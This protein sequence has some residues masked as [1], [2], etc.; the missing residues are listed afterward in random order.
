MT[1]RKLRAGRV[2]QAQAETWVG[3]VGMI[4]YNEQTGTLRIS[5]G[6]TPGGNPLTLVAEDF[7][8][9]FGDFVAFGN[10]Q[11]TIGVDQDFNIES[12]G[13]GTVNIVGKLDI[14]T[15]AQGVGG[16]AVFRINE[17]GFTRIN[18][19]PIG[20]GESGLL[21]TSAGGIPQPPQVGG[22]ILHLVG[23]DG[24]SSRLSHD[25]F[26]TGAIPV[27]IAR[28]GR[29]TLAMPLPSQSGDRL[30]RFSALGW[31][32]TNY[33]VAA[34]N[35]SPSSIDFV[36]TETYTD[37]VCG[38][39]V[40]IYATPTGTNT[41][42]LSATFTGTGVTATTFT[43]NATSAT[44][45]QTARTINGTSFDGTANITVAAAAGTLTGATLNA[46]V[47]ASSLTQLGTLSTL[48][49]SGATVLQGNITA[50]SSQTINI[51]PTAGALTIN[52]TAASTMNNL[53]I[54]LPAGTA[55]V[56]PL[57][58]TTGTNLT[59][60]QAG[61]VGYDGTIFHAT[62]IG[63]QRGLLL[64]E[65]YLVLQSDRNLNF[66][67]TAAQ[68]IFAT[69]PTLSAN[70]RYYLRLKAFVSRTS[71]DNNTALTLGFGGT[72]VL[73]R[74]GY[75]VQSRAGAL[76]V[77]GTGNTCDNV[78]TTNFTTQAAV[79]GV[80]NPPSAQSFL[81]TALVDVG[82]TGGTFI[83]QFS[84]TGA[85]AAGASVVAA[86]ST[87]HIYPVG[88]SGVDTSVGQWV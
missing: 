75:A 74:V 4:F 25:V 37:T 86:P 23:S 11:S 19:P 87:F 24:M 50:T 56:P 9:T 21:V 66:A 79:T 80:A 34:G 72:A 42:T 16:D 69:N 52:P 39:R 40:E 29:G 31:G 73:S 35:Q 46:T 44:A 77:V 55:T 71:G 53:S 57:K 59:T 13:T 2:S 88:P 6:V 51:S 15:T 60:P 85:T 58:F 47:T 76:G 64:V 65:Q 36:A 62:P 33:A 82:A 14:H 70:T 20:V 18:V 3:P 78:I 8:F 38:A 83:P 10:T 28:H 26:G 48:T 30:G 81:I 32:A 43:G 63:Q 41:R 67:T 49:V 54:T 84:W 61:A 7:Q 17:F 45:L 68:A 22:V 1:I 27:F 12:N 5:D